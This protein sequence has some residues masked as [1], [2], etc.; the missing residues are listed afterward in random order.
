M[1]SGYNTVCWIIFCWSNATKKFSAK[2][3]G[4]FYSF[5]LLYLYLKVIKSTSTNK[6]VNLVQ[7]DND[8]YSQSQ[9][10]INIYFNR[11]SRAEKKIPQNTNK[12][13]SINF[14]AW[15]I[16][17]NS[18]KNTIKKWENYAMHC[19]MD[20]IKQTENCCW[21]FFFRFSWTLDMLN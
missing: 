2:E 4:T 11:N 12:Y 21:I 14:L 5:F 20:G 7:I 18:A 16:D 17:V 3:N 1:N 15:H 8:S 9:K 10:Q 13:I 19:K 6:Y